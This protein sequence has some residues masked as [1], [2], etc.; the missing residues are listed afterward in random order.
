MHFYAGLLLLLSAV[1]AL[2]RRGIGFGAL[3]RF[4]FRSLRMQA[5][6]E[7]LGARASET[8]HFADATAPA[9][10]ARSGDDVCADIPA[11]S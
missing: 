2:K 6:Y 7:A 10:S 9:A 4:S 8:A 5:P 3:S 1:V 11:H